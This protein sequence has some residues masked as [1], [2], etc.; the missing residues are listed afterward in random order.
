MKD[1]KL[2]QSVVIF[3]SAG[4]NKE[5]NLKLREELPSELSMKIF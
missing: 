3:D 2:S 4:E 1:K 5:T